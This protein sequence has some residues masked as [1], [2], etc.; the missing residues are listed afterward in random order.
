L[1]SALVKIDD[2][3][4]RVLNT[5]KA[6]YGLRDKGQAIDFVVEKFAEMSDEP[7][8]RKSFIEDIKKSQSQ[9]SIVVSDFRKRY[10]S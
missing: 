6:M 3:T 4:N 2:E 1:V 9:K 5:V 10:G 7:T 8:L